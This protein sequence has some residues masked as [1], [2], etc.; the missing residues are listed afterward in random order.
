MAVD[1]KTFRPVEFDGLTVTF[2]V[3]GGKVTGVNFKQ[4]ANTTPLKRVDSSQ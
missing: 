1:Q 4:G 3:E 2:N